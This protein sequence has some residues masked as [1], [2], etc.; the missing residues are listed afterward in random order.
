VRQ[1]VTRWRPTPQRKWVK[2]GHFSPCHCSLE[3][4]AVQGKLAFVGGTGKN[5]DETQAGRASVSNQIHLTKNATKPSYCQLIW[6]N[7]CRIMVDNPWRLPRSLCFEFR[8]TVT[9]L[10]STSVSR[11]SQFLPEKVNTVPPTILPMSMGLFVISTLSH[12]SPRVQQTK[13]LKQCR[14]TYNNIYTWI[15]KETH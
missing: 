4:D 14:Y 5:Y 1:D 2:C 13:Q 15:I 9:C 3:T 7:Q 8:H 10:E 12:S 6:S 11:F